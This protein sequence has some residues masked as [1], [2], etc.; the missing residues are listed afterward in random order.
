VNLES[1]TTLRLAEIPNIVGVKESSGNLGQITTL[2]NKAPNGFKVLAGDD[3]L[4]LPVLAL[5]GA[6][7]VSVASNAIPSEM[8]HMVGAALAGR[9]PSARKINREWFRLMEAHFW[10]PSPAPVKAVLAILGRC[11]EKLRLPMVPVNAATRNKLETLVQELGLLHEAT[12]E[13]RS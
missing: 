8:S 10:E 2:I 13:S 1:A 11:E 7:L 9:W 3:G 4:A 5:G 6:G 12:I